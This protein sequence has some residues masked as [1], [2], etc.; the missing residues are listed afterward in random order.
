[1]TA[2]NQFSLLLRLVLLFTFR[3]LAHL[4]LTG[5]TS[6]R[7][8]ASSFPAKNYGWSWATEI[9]KKRSQTHIH[10]ARCVVFPHLSPWIQP[11][12]QKRR[13]FSVALLRSSVPT[14]TCA[15]GAESVTKLLFFVFLVGDIPQV[16]AIP[17]V[18]S[19][20]CFLLRSVSACGSLTGKQNGRQGDSVFRGHLR[21][22]R[23][24]KNTSVRTAAPVESQ[25][26]AQLYR[27]RESA[28]L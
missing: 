24:R 1:M 14:D 9:F 8:P 20:L 27:T 19:S 10:R 7:L 18:R 6:A 15:Y 26:H 5:V 16:E 22:P 21:S 4:V 11:E 12:M 23:K 13:C 17:S 2:W 25:H 3:L 28:T